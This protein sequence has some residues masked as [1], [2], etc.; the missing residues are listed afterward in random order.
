MRVLT[1][2]KKIFLDTRASDFVIPVQT[3]G[4]C[5]RAEINNDGIYNRIHLL[6]T[7]V[8][9]DSAVFRANRF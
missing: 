4:E 2:F 7:I 8:G 6:L 1:R 5:I 9:V 3:R